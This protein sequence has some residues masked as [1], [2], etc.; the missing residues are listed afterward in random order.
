MDNIK[1]EQKIAKVWYAPKAPHLNPK[2]N[3]PPSSSTFTPLSHH[4]QSS[5]CGH[6]GN[7]EIFN[8]W[9]GSGA[10]LESA[11]PA[12]CKTPATSIDSIWPN[13]QPRRNKKS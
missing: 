4:N 8:L 7:N 2:I 3:Q 9:L 12:S 13:N 11:S 6:V 10:A 1:T 5:G